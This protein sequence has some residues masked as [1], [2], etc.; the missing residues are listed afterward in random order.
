MV[1][2]LAIVPVLAVL[3]GPA[4]APAADNA[5]PVLTVCEV[6]SDLQKYES[7]SVIV[8]GRL[9]STEE[10]PGWMRSAV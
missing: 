6:L 9:G 3:L 10:G 5:P 4:F 2:R 8:V 7:N 1:L